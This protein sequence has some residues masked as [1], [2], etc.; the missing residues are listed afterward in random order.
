VQVDAL[1]LQR[2]PEAFDEDV[3]KEAPAP[4]HRDAHAE[5]FQG[6]VQAQAVNWL[7]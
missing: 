6:C 1:V 7:P 5:V 4:V 3:V 2:P